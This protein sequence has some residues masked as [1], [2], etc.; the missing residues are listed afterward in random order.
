MDAAAQ[1]CAIMYLSMLARSQRNTLAFY[2]AARRNMSADT[3]PQIDVRSLSLTQLQ[4]LATRGSQRARGELERRMAKAD[5]VRRPEVSAPSPDNM[6]ARNRAPSMAAPDRRDAPALSRDAQILQ[7]QA[8]AQEDELRER[9]A[10]APGLIGMALMA[11]GMLM[12]FG[13][14][15]MMA[16]R[17]GLYYLLF[18]LACAFIG[19]LLL[20]CKRA[21]IWAQAAC[22]AAALLWAW[23][24]YHYT[25]NALWLA[26]S[27][28]APVWIAALWIVVPMVR[29]PLN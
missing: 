29:A 18:G 23:S 28:S 7:L 8:L 11:W 24:N 13:G 20:R 12:L 27:Q 21:A 16:H 19:W 5:A 22:V 2:C 25:G 3:S 26:L 17:N 4:R 9:A 10:R 15:V 14:A 6:T 1:H